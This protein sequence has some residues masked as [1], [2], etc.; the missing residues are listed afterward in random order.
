MERTSSGRPGSNR[1][2]AG[3]GTGQWVRAGL[4]VGRRPDL[5]FT[6]ARQL[7]RLVPPRWWQRS[8]HLPIPDPAYLRFRMV[9]AYGG[10]G[11]AP[12]P[13]D[14]VTYLHWCRAWPSLTSTSR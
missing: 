5:W 8:P 12:T 11:G 2:T 6:A 4:A 3:W 14:V 13:D 7:R 9:T 10:Q 1:G